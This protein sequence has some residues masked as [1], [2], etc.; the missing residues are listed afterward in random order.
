MKKNLNKKDI[1]FRICSSVSII[2]SIC[3][4][5]LLRKLAGDPTTHM[6]TSVLVILLLTVLNIAV[7]VLY[8]IIKNNRK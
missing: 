4:F 1:V 2:L 8:E 5:G 7:I 6:I 3:V